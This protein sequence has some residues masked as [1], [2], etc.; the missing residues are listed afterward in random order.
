M[1]LNDAKSG[2]LEATPIARG[3]GPRS[4]NFVIRSFVRM[5]CKQNSRPV[6]PNGFHVRESNPRSIT[7]MEDVACAQQTLVIILQS[8]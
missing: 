4:N 8:K 2:Y 6:N 5:G 7:V 1:Y 3:T